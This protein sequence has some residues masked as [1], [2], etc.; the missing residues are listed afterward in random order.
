[1]KKRLIA[2]C[3]LAAL[4]LAA[5]TMAEVR[6]GS[7]SITPFAGGY[8]F[9]GDQNIKGGPTFGLRGGY[10]FTKNLGLEGVF[11]YTPTEESKGRQLDVDSYTYRLEGLYHFMPDSKFV[12]FLAV[13]AGG[14]TQNF[15]DGS[16]YDDR[17]A[18]IA[19]Y[20]GGVKY[21][22]T[23]A[24][25]VRGDVRGIVDINNPYNNVE[26]TI[27]L[28]YIFGGEKP[29]A[30]AA[31]PAPA[32]YVEPAPE[33]AP[34]PLAAEPRPDLMKYC[35]DLKI[36][37][38]IDKSEIRPQ[39]QDEVK[40]VADFM[41]KYPTT[42]AV[43]EGHTDSV[44]DDAYNMKLSQSRA[45]AVVNSLVDNFGIDRSRLSAKGYGETRP[46]ADNATE[47]GKQKNRRIEAVIDCALES[48]KV[49]AQLPDRLCVTLKVQF[50][51]DKSDIKPQYHDEIAKVG[52]F[53]K[54][55]PTTTAIIEGHTDR[56]GSA[57]YNMKLSQRRAE[58][59]VNYLVEKFGIEKSRLS[60][61]GYGYT[62]PIG[63][64]TTAEGRALNR[65]INA[66]IDCVIKK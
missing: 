10:N 28:S 51:T 50:D 47:A 43:I 9:E 6:P 58:A 34:A 40:K 61:K 1:M 41:K 27:G 5:P 48:P 35:I 20:G 60:A 62:R 22:I 46:I 44:G 15:S 54:Q 19:T 38:D 55:N 53:M 12:P 33:P 3:A 36:E 8:T 13:G 14:I 64:N 37:F 59:V 42:T 49:V 7:F 65:R 24:F 63:Y 29:V 17:N 32:P 23:E 30:K 4:A 66:I 25:A 11:G 2:G 16:R 45:E 31:P 52:D 26:Y 57:D 21:F 39:Y 56:I 18:F